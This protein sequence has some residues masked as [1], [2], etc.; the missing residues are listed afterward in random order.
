MRLNPLWDELVQIGKGQDCQPPFERWQ[1]R[2][3]YIGAERCEQQA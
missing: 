2:H 3:R 1:D